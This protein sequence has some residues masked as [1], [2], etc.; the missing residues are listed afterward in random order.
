M[1][2]LNIIHI[3]HFTLKNTTY[4]MYSVH[5]TPTIKTSYY[6]STICIFLII[7]IIMSMIVVQGETLIR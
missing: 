2:T 7:N 4:L 1:Y 6:T 5:C 3:H